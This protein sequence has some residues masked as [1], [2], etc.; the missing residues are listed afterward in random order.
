MEH[1][2]VFSNVY[3][4]FDIMFHNSRNIS[5]LSIE[6]IITDRAGIEPGSPIPESNA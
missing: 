4:I 3:S 5:A 2:N 6:C 1:R